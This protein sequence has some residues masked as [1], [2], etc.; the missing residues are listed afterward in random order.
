MVSECGEAIFI[1]PTELS[2]FVLASIAD[3]TSET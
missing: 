2:N 3:T 1:G